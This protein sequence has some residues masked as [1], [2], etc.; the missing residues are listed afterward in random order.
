VPT[1]DQY[2]LILQLLAGLK[3]TDYPN[4]EVILVDN[5]STD[6]RVLAL[7]ETLKLQDPSLRVLLRR[8]PFNFSRSIN[9]GVE[10]A[11]GDAVLFLNNDI[12][13]LEP[14]WLKEMVSCLQYGG[15]GIVG[16]RLLY[17]DRSLQHAGVIVGFGGLAGHWYIGQAKDFPGPQGRLRV[18]N[19]YSAV[20]GACLLA[21]RSCL[22]ATGPLDEHDFAIAYNDVDFCMRA[23]GLGFRVVWTPFAT[24]IHHESAS[25]G[26]D[27]TPENLD[28][29]NLE[30]Q[31]LAKRHSTGGYVDPAV[32]PWMSRDRAYPEPVKLQDLPEAR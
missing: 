7:Y 26:S 27:E 5:G 19:S 16:A 2:E 9:R 22:V 1:K 20:T 4:Y 13:I 31:N 29:F 17:P 10:V 3:Q 6:S 30:K 21:T 23:R 18:R 12:E 8:E 24:L 11:R 28:R 14:T 15:V 25:R 32:S